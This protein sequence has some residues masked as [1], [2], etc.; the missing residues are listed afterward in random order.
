MDYGYDEVDEASEVRLGD[1]ILRHIPG[2]ISTTGVY[3][4]SS[5]VRI[6]DYRV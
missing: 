2:R 1:Q 5:S 3:I 6:G 4:C